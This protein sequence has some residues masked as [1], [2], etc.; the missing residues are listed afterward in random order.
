MIHVHH[1]LAVTVDEMFFGNWRYSVEISEAPFP[2][3]TDVHL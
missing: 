3:G 1:K 2:V